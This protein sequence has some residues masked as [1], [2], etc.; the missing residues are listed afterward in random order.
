MSQRKSDRVDASGVNA[1]VTSR[2][3]A[4]GSSEAPAVSTHRWQTFSVLYQKVARQAPAA[5]AV[6]HRE[7]GRKPRGALGGR[8][9]SHTRGG[10]YRENRWRRWRAGASPRG[11]PREGQRKSD[12]A[13]TGRGAEGQGVGADLGPPALHRPGTP[14]PRRVL[15]ANRAAAGSA[16]RNA[17]LSRTILNLGNPEGYERLTYYE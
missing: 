15:P 2:A 7:S 3:G 11:G 17:L 12:R 10:K 6:L 8:G 9:G 1:A 14:A 4:S 16:E 5:P 13:R